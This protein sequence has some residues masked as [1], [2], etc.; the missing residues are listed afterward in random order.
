[1]PY[2]GNIPECL[3]MASMYRLILELSIHCL[4][5]CLDI[6]LHNTTVPRAFH[7]VSYVIWA[8]FEHEPMLVNIPEYS[9]R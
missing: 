6:A 2:T 3:W 4:D 1:M 9:K 7:Y 5:N 8:L